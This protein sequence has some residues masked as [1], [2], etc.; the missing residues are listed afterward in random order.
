MIKVFYFFPSRKKVLLLCLCALTWRGVEMTLESSL[1]TYSR[2]RNK[3]R[4]YV[5]YFCILSR[6]TALLKG[7]TF[8]EFWVLIHSLQIFWFFLIWVCIFCSLFLST[9]PGP[10]FIQG[11]TFIILSNFP[12]PT[13]IPCPT[14]VYSGV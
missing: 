6:P 2:L 9:F 4:P 1:I 7:T 13:F 8:I 12:C 3:R 5:Y 10:T 11:P 14:Y